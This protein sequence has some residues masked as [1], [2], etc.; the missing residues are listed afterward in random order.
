MSDTD[1]E[2]G[3]AAR[4]FEDLRAEVSVLRRALEA[5]PVAWQ[6]NQPPDYTPSLSAI[7][8]RLQDV[9]SRLET[10]EGH[11][12]LRVTA[13]Q[14]GRSMAQ[15]GRGIVQD[16]ASRLD[17]TTHDTREHAKH[18]EAII[19][20]ARTQ[21]S[22]YRWLIW[23][24][25]IALVVGLILSPAIAGLLPFGLDGRIA[26]FIMN[27]DRWQA[28]QNLMKVADPAGWAT[29]SAEMRLAVTNHDALAACREAAATAKKEQR[30][31]IIVPA[32]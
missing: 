13:E 3:S 5:L 6:A 12:A 21:D 16:A 8:K 2:A 18:L 22:H 25:A 14:H 30:C 28:G 10:I 4:A 7:S 27:G 20:S 1:D 17:Q 29:L 32:P 19:G 31:S 24:G 11:P 9:S 15:A 23:T 26:A